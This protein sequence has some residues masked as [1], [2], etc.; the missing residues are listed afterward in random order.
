M[1]VIVVDSKVTGRPALL[2]GRRGRLLPTKYLI[3]KVYLFSVLSKL[4]FAIRLRRTEV[5]TY[6]LLL[7]YNGARRMV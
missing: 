7:L 3:I 6:Q 4:R 2:L 1:R 5:S